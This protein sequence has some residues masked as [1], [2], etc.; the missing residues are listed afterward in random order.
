[1]KLDLESLTDEQRNVVHLY[2]KEHEKLKRYE[3]EMKE[4]KT[5]VED[6]LNVL[7]TIREKE[8]KLF[9]NGK[10]K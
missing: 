10:E 4:L 6:T 5:K 3:R 1:M 9:D 7:K 8:I 2:Q